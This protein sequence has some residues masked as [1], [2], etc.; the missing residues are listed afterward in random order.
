MDIDSA[1]M[2]R[3]LILATLCLLI[4]LPLAS[5]GSLT[6]L[7]DVSYARNRVVDFFS[8]YDSSE[9]VFIEGSEI[10]VEDQAVFRFFKLQTSGIEKSE[11]LKDSSVASLGSLGKECVVVLGG[12]KTNLF[13]SDLMESSENGSFVVSEEVVLAPYQLL[14]GQ[15]NESG[16]HLLWIYSEKELILLENNAADRSL[17]GLVLDKKIVPIAATLLSMLLLWLWQSLGTTIVE[18]FSDFFSEKAKE[19]RQKKR[20]IKKLSRQKKELHRFIDLHE[21]GAI[22][23]SSLVFSGVFTWVWVDELSSFW[24]LYLTN[25]LV[26]GGVL[27]VSESLRQYWCYS[28]KVSSEFVFWPFGAVLTVGSTLLGNTF[29]LASHPALADGEDEKKFGKIAFRVMLIGL[30]V[31]ILSYVYNILYPSR[32]VQMLFVFLS[33]EIFIEMFPLQPMDGHDVKKWNPL[34]WGVFYV[35]VVLI[36]IVVNFT[37]FLEG[38]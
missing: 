24:S 15:L 31:V 14:F 37:M 4:C 32:I 6:N 11:T 23:A 10:P 13:G 29:S 18:F 12:P 3:L 1:T 38:M 17:F 8:D 9:L 33:M 26:V 2:K 7:D 25:F 36:Y 22:L 30:I 28:S 20:G 19:R 27:L 35:F 34:V 21:L 16:V 5:A